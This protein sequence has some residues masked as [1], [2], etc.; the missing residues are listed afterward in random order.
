MRWSSRQPKHGPVEGD[1]R[2]RTAFLFFPKTIEGQTRW[3]EKAS[4]T[5]RYQWIWTTSFS[6]S[7]WYGWVPISWT[8][9]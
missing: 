2:S 7:Y 6:G 9:H 3:L 5:E 4:W 1:L 8:S